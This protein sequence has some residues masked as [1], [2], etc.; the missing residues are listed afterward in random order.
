[1]AVV[2]HIPDYNIEPETS[3][4]LKAFI[5]LMLIDLVVIMFGLTVGV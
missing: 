1:M 4:P 3:L 2:A 5:I